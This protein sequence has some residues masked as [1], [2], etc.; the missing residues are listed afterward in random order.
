MR[1]PFEL[2]GLRL[3]DRDPAIARVMLQGASAATVP[4]TALPIAGN[5]WFGIAYPCWRGLG[6]ENCAKRRFQ[7]AR[8]RSCLQASVRN[9]GLLREYVLRKQGKSAGE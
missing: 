9:E 2:Y 7:A 6:A 5:N 4:T 3:S 1:R 8:C